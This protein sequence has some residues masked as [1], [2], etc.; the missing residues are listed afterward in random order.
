M[1]KKGASLYAP[2]PLLT[3][4]ALIWKQHI[5]KRGFPNYDDDGDN[6]DEDDDEQIVGCQLARARPR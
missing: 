1:C 2:P 4:N 3:G 6:D 5:S